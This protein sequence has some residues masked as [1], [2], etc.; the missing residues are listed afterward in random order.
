MGGW[1]AA[2]GLSLDRTQAGVSGWVGGTRRLAFADVGTV[3]G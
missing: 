1:G 3:A 2:S